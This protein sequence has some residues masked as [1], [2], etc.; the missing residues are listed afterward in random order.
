M[1]TVFTASSMRTGAA[2]ALSPR[3]QH[4]AFSEHLRALKAAKIALSRAF[5]LNP[6]LRATALE[7]EDLEPLWDSLATEWPASI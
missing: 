1:S 3:L 6:D 7:D 4:Q 5:K 2:S